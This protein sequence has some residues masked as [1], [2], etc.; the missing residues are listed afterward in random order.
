M[1]NPIWARMSQDSTHGMYDRRGAETSSPLGKCLMPK[2]VTDVS[3]WV[4]MATTVGSSKRQ[5][6]TDLQL[7]T[8]A[9]KGQARRHAWG[10]CGQ[11]WIARPM[12]LIAPLSR[13]LLPLRIRLST[14]KPVMVTSANNLSIAQPSRAKRKSCPRQ[15]PTSPCHHAIPP[16]ARLLSPSR[17]RISTS[18]LDPRRR[19]LPLCDIL[20]VALVGEGYD[21]GENLSLFSPVT[22]NGKNWIERERL[23]R[24]N[25]LNNTPL[26][27]YYKTLSIFFSSQTF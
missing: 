13:S 6:A 7:T 11:G 25:M 5:L 26:I 19:H 3:L 18:S 22:R 16:Y 8:K 27:S 10:C 2:G 9:T 14:R 1:L 20:F 24:G 15:L 21:E 4:L 12:P 23:P 17:P